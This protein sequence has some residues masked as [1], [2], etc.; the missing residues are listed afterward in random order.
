MERSVESTARRA[1][2]VFILLVVAGALGWYLAGS[3]QYTTYQI[4]TQDSV[5]GLLVDAPVEFHGVEVG[6]V[7]HINLADP[8]TVDILLQIRKEVPVTATTIATITTRGLANRGFM[9]YVYISLEDAGPGMSAATPLAT[10]PGS[11]FPSI[12]ATH[13]RLVTLDTTI[14]QVN[15][16]VQAITTL[17]QTALDKQSLAAL[18]QS[19]DD[20]QKITQ[21]LAANNEKLGSIILNTE[22]ASNRIKPLL[23]SGNDTVKAMQTQ[24]LPQA[25]KALSDL[26]NLSRSLG[27]LAT[28]MN[29]DPSILIRG[30]NRPAPGPGEGNEGR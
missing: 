28:K 17:A 30:S 23:E 6:K 20:L 29:R 14:S 9:G 21:T 27:G 10:L 15:E 7:Q 16:N 22:R 25:Y 24:I 11:S 4:R 8:R 18:K 26:D 13:P 1:F 5:S 3:A 12:P 2:A 19:L